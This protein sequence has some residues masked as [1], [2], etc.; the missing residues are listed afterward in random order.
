M[1]EKKVTKLKTID[2]A[3]GVFTANG[4]DYFIESELSIERAVW[5][6]HFTLELETGVAVGKQTQ[7]WEKAWS[8]CNEMKFGDLAVLCHEN[9]QAF[10]KLF[11]NKPTILKLCALF[12]NTADEDRRTI[13]NTLIDTKIS[14]WF[15]EGYSFQ[16]FLELALSILSVEVESLKKPTEAILAKIR[17][18]NQS[19]QEFHIPILS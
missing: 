13:N 1:E 9:R 8:L 6:E 4:Q 15:E 12:C 5:K 17:E 11:E 19:I 10:V 14:D 16:S 7:D 18:F 2:F 3:T